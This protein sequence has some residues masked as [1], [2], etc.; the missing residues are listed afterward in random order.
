MADF[1]PDAF[2]IWANFKGIWTDAGA[3]PHLHPT[4]MREFSKDILKHSRAE[5]SPTG[6]SCT[7]EPLGRK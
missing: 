6:V 5:P 1:A 2:N 4:R 7:H 3:E